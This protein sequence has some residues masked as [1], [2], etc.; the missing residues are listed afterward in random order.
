MTEPRPEYQHYVPQ[1]LLRNFAHPYK[2]KGGKKRGKRKDENGI[3]KN[4]LVVHNLD[5]TADPPVICENPVKRIFGQMDMYEDTSKPP[6]KQRHIEE[7]L[8]KLESQASTIFQKITKGFDNASTLD[9]TSGVSLTRDERN[10]LRK[11]LFILHYRNLGFH[12]R[13]SHERPE[14]YSSNDRA[15]MQEYMERKGY[16]RPIDVWFDGLTAIMDQDF[17]T[18]TNW[19][20]EILRK[21]Y[22]ADAMWFWGHIQMYYM[23]ICTPLDPSEEFL[24]TD[25]SYGVF[26]GPN[27]YGLNQESK[28]VEES[29]YTPLHYFAPIS[30]KL[31]LVLRS[32]IFPY[33]AEDAD[34]QVREAREF[35]RR[36]AFDDVYGT[37]PGGKMGKLHDLPVR[38]AQNSYSDI[39]DGRV[40]FKPG[41]D[42]RLLRTDKFFFPFFPIGSHHV[43]TINSALLDSCSICTRIVFNSVTSFAKTIEW[44]LSSPHVGKILDLGPNDG[45]E[46]AIRKIEEISRSLGSTKKMAR[47]TVVPLPTPKGFFERHTAKEQEYMKIWLKSGNTRE[48]LEN[49]IR[50]SRSSDGVRDERSPSGNEFMALYEKLGG[51]LSTFCHDWDQG[52]RMWLL[53]MKLD[54]WSQGVDEGIRQRNRNL[55]N[56]AYNRLPPSRMWLFVRKRRFMLLHTGPGALPFPKGPNPMFNNPED[57]IVRGN[58]LVDPAKLS[59]LINN[60]AQVDTWVKKGLWQ[61]IWEPLTSDAD[62][63]Q[64]SYYIKIAIHDHGF[65]RECGIPEIEDLARKAQ[66]QIIRSPEFRECM[67]VMNECPGVLEQ[68]EIIELW[69]RSRVRGMFKSALADKVA[70][71]LLDRLKVVFFEMAYPTPDW[72]DMN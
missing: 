37:A 21:M 57:E 26:E 38:I 46:R 33:A 55:L 51:S 45:R 29:A 50:M 28:E 56:E 43:N 15:V 58:H 11:F 20:Q 27:C 39:I 54:S 22:P 4:E 44:F 16:K 14:Q 49:F 67:E 36:M 19:A 30:P 62:G 71:P 61:R 42:G 18:S 10:V 6:P 60:V 53:R 9:G 66:K 59:R 70:A 65:I 25:S 52:T 24:L 3:Y 32:N 17:N 68:G 8:G 47:E 40:V 69:T 63:I 35:G 5:L 31:M 7:R 41:H 13:F 12:K 72:P 1:F 64:R 23:A 2:P 48:G 34:P